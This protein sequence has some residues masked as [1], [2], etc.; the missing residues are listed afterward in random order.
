MTVD[1]FFRGSWALYVTGWL[2]YEDALIVQ[3]LHKRSCRLGWRTYARH[4]WI[5]LH[6]YRNR[7]TIAWCFFKRGVNMM[8]GWP[9]VK[10]SHEQWQLLCDGAV[11]IWMSSNAIGKDLRLQSFSLIWIRRCPSRDSETFYRPMGGL[12]DWSSTALA[13]YT[14]RV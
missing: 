5:F 9:R 2:S 14:A 12:C 11:R 8:A 6:E 7:P 1:H 13:A 10:F 4:F 3:V